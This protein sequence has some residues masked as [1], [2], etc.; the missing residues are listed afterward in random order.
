MQHHEDRALQGVLVI[1]D[2]SASKTPKRI[3]VS[4]LENWDTHQVELTSDK[5]PLLGRYRAMPKGQS[6]GGGGQGAL[7][8]SLVTTIKVVADS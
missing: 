2:P 3:C 1:P 7:Q 8:R 6:P 5:M 4:I